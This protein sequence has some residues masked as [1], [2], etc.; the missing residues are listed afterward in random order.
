MKRV[1]PF[2]LVVLF[3]TMGCERLASSGNPEDHIAKVNVTQSGEIS[4]NGKS[5]SLEEL[6]SEL[7]RIKLLGGAVWYSR[8]APN[9][10]PSEEAMKVF[11]VVMSSELPIKLVK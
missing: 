2:L 3:L 6:K 1:L 9:E 8:E 11:E 7:A 5:V 4:L 10:E